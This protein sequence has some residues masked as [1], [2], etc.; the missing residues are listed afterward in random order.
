MGPPVSGMKRGEI[1]AIPLHCVIFALAL[2]ACFTPVDSHSDHHHQPSDAASPSSVVYQWRHGNCV[3]DHASD[4]YSKVQL[5]T[6]YHI[7]G[8]NNFKVSGHSGGHAL[9]TFRPE[10]KDCASDQMFSVKYSGSVGS[11]LDHP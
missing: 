10:V 11:C 3:A 1:I 8:G 6:C 7:Q 9:E 2:I 4:K 5:E